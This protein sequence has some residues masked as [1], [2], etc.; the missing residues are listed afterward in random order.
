MAQPTPYNRTAD[1][2][3]REGNDTNHTALNAEFDAVETT[4]DQLC[5]NLA[6]LQRDDGGLRQGIVGADALAPSA[7]ERV[8]GS[9]NDAVLSADAAANLALQEAAAAKQ[10]AGNA[11]IHAGSAAAR[12]A[13]ASG[14]AANAQ[15]S[16]ANA[17]QSVA[18]AGG[19]AEQVARDTVA[20]VVSQVDHAKTAAQQAATSAEQTRQLAQQAANSAAGALTPAA[21]DARYAPKH[22]P[23]FTKN[24]ATLHGGA[25]YLQTA[26]DSAYENVIIDN[27]N[28]GIRIYARR[29]AD[30]VYRGFFGQID[31]LANDWEKITTEAWVTG[32]VQAQGYATTGW[33]QAQG[34]ATT[35]W[36]DNHITS[37]LVNRDIHMLGGY[38]MHVAGIVP[39][40]A[41]SLRGLN[42]LSGT[43]MACHNIESGHAGLWRR[44]A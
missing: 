13:D 7:F 32:W 20:P 34:Y 2:T 14:S 42:G 41:G 35:G 29:K 5:H 6:L 11:A 40:F 18:T 38:T 36:A 33:V 21:G 31:H 3:E 39:A 26:D 4:V 16:A 25:V 10:S 15:Q 8:L 28:N 43:W 23:V 22:N 9:V 37:R 44:V 30:G 19:I 1:F 24:S 27:Y 17:A 12:A